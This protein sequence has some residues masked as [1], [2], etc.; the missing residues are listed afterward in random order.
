MERY[1]NNI[2]TCYGFNRSGYR[3]G[4]YFWLSGTPLPDG[5]DVTET[6]FWGFKVS[7][8]THDYY[9]SLYFIHPEYFDLPDFD[10]MFALSSQS[11]VLIR[12]SPDDPQNVLFRLHQDNIPPD[13]FFQHH[14]GVFYFSAPEEVR[15][16][17]DRYA[18]EIANNA[19]QQEVRI[20]TNTLV[21]EELTMSET[22]V[23]PIC[24]V[25]THMCHAVKTVC[26]HTY[27]R[28]CIQQWV[29][30]QS[31]STCPLCRGVIC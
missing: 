30:M 5:L 17:L 7:A 10:E 8:E 23:C 25:N 21:K 9:V 19:P 3:H 20:V 31:L 24:L 12:P 29:N 4:F 27:C 11:I 2:T 13:L 6:F 15:E 28:E 22:F 26:N 16:M 1:N 14:D 18:Q